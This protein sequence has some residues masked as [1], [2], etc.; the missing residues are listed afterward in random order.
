MLTALLFPKRAQ[1]Y[2]HARSTLELG[3]PRGSNVND[4]R[5]PLPILCRLVY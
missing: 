1:L 3:N 2:R 4:L 5:F